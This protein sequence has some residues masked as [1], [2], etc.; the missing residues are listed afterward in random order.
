MAETPWLMRRTLG[1]SLAGGLAWSILPGSQSALAAPVAVGR[2]AS[3]RPGSVNTW[4]IETPGGGLVV[5]D[6]QRSYKEASEALSLISR[7]GKP[8]RA[9]LVTHPHPDHVNGLGLYR[10]TLPGVPVIAQ[11]ATRD[12]IRADTSGYEK[13]SADVR[14]GE[15][16]PVPDVVLAD[17]EHFAM[18]GL[19]IEARQ[20][21]PGEA[22]G[23]TVYW[24]PELRTLV[25]GDVATPGFLPFLVEGRTR[26]WLGQLDQ[27]Q[28]AY[29]ADAQALPGHGPAGALGAMADQ[30]AAYLTIYRNL[31]REAMLPHS[32]AGAKLTPEAR[33]YLLAEM[34]R[35]YPTSDTTSNLPHDKLLAL[36]LDAVRRELEQAD[37]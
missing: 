24:L 13:A 20:L 18:D 8:V 2:Y 21:G 26:A 28:A 36:N 10:R 37:R 15:P 5:V 33:E 3:V 9:V 19:A 16:V 29:P 11:A 14:D 31:M 30:Q 35:R 32:Q 6:A 17:S 12:E 22:V 1:R 27:V 23:L 25:S 34:E 4:W 7:T